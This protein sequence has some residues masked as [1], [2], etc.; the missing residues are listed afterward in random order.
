MAHR[1]TVCYSRRPTGWP[2][3]PVR[4]TISLL[5]PSDCQFMKTRDVLAAPEAELSAKLK[6]MKPKELDRHAEK[7]LA[8]FGVADHKAVIGSVIK[9]LPDF[10]EQSPDRYRRVQEVVAQKV[11]QQHQ[12]T[13]VVGDTLARIAIIIVVLITKQFEKIHRENR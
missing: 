4:A 3:W 8:K 7:I 11:P 6:L 12:H 13:L 10:D 1:F 2:W 5:N 9:V